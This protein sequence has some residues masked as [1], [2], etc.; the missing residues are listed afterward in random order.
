MASCTHQ[1]LRFHSTDWG[2][3]GYRPPS[4]DD[5]REALQLAPPNKRK[6][7]ASAQSGGKAAAV[8][9]QLPSAQTFPAPLVNED[10]ELYHDPDYPPQSLQEWRDEAARNKVTAKRRTIYVVPPPEVAP[11]AGFVRNWTRPSQTS[12]VRGKRKAAVLSPGGKE[13]A[14]QAPGVEDVAAYLRAFYHGL[15]VRVLDKPV[16]RFNRWTEDDSQSTTTTA[17]ALETGT[18]AIRTR[19]RPS[20][21]NIFT[22]QLNLNDLLDAAI[23]ILPAD[24]SA[25]LLLVHHDL[26]EDA[27]DDFCCGRAYGGSRVAVVSSARYHPGLDGG[28]SVDRAHAW[29]ASHCAV[30]P[31]Q[32]KPSRRK[33]KAARERDADS[34][35]AAAVDAFAALPAPTTAAALSSLWLARVCKTASHELG[36]CFGIDHCTYFACAMQGTANVGED[37]RQPPYLCPVDLAKVL[38]ATGAG[39]RERYEALVVFCEEWGEERMFAAFAAWIRVRLGQ[40]GVF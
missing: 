8:P 36:H 17:L 18:E 5:I 24:A 7:T 27:T 25:L 12:A 14:V 10:D 26:H 28:Q 31:A 40:G 19:C 21:D 34:A 33:G 29:P 37:N 32:S 23:D 11:E 6:K 1:Q 22:G 13:T 15:P 39:E 30:A 3:E 2:A 16:L 4:A 9:I 38:A 35:I 20:P